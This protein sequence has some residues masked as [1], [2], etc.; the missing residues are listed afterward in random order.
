MLI[1]KCPQCISL[2]GC[3][4]SIL[5]ALLTLPSDSVREISEFEKNGSVQEVDFGS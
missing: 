5:T 2:I 1:S 4:N 3:T